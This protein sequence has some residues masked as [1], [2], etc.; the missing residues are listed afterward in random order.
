MNKIP[1][2]GEI[3][4]ADL[5]MPV[6]SEQR[7]RRPVLILQNDIGNKHSPTVI[8]ACITSE[9]KGSYLPVHCGIPDGI[10]PKKSTILFEQ[11]RTLDK[12]RLQEKVGYVEPSLWERA[13]L[14]SMGV[15]E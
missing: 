8:V 9:N 4:F 13:L 7:G 10:M 15:I 2:R 14:I 3:Y 11:I 1:M 12:S 5:G 6:G